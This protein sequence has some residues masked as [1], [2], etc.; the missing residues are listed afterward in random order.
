MVLDADI[1]SVVLRFV[2]TL[3]EAPRTSTALRNRARAA[4][5]GGAAYRRVNRTWRTSIENAIGRALPPMASVSL[6]SLLVPGRLRFVLLSCRYHNDHG[7]VSAYDALVLRA[8][9]VG[10]RLREAAAPRETAGTSALLTANG[11]GS[12]GA[13]VA[14]ARESGPGNDNN[15]GGIRTSVGPSGGNRN[16]LCYRVALKRIVGEALR[17]P[18]FSW[19]STL[20]PDDSR[21]LEG[22]VGASSL[23]QATWFSI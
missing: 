3:D 15:N 10:L 2:D 13:M 19:C 1:L 12:A 4:V 21:L 14:G 7:I 6:A 5:R 9:A 22:C 11:S 18:A 8:E 16:C 20:G 17:S 23:L